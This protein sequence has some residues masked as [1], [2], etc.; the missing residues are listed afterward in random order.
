MG[1]CQSHEYHYLAEIGDEVISQCLNCNYTKKHD[2][3][4]MQQDCPNCEGTLTNNN[5]IEVSLF[6]I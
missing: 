3:N 4:A 2:A 6:E 1:G 5:G